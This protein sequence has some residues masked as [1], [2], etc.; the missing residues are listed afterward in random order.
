MSELC[1]SRRLGRLVRPV[2]SQVNLV[3]SVVDSTLRINFQT[4]YKLLSF[5]W[6]VFTVTIMGFFLGGV[7]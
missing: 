1:C 4:S 7:Y 6:I 3:V 5:Q 2:F